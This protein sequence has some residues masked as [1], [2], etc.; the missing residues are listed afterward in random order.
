MDHLRPFGRDGR[1]HDREAPREA[2]RNFALDP[3]AIP[4]RRD[5]Q[6]TRVEM[7]AGSWT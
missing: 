1:R 6:A 3:G 4:D 5:R 7:G 2:M